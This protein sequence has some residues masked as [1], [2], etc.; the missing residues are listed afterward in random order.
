MKSATAAIEET[1]NL[2]ILNKHELQGMCR[3]DMLEYLNIFHNEYKSFW[4]DLPDDIRKDPDFIQYR[5][6]DKP[7]N[8]S[9][10]RTSKQLICCFCKIRKFKLATQKRVY[11]LCSI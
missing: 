3:S 10:R 8:V 9:D 4:D 5:P 1:S 6:V 11:N 2:T 7:A